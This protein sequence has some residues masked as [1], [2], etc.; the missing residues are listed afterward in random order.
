MKTFH[1]EGHVPQQVLYGP[2]A[3]IES[4]LT[5][6]NWQEC[7]ILRAKQYLY[8][9]VGRWGGTGDDSL[10]YRVDTS[11]NSDLSKDFASLE[12]AIDYANRLGKPDKELPFKPSSGTYVGVRFGQYREGLSI[13][14]KENK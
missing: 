3:P 13:P 9:G 7:A 4:K 11:P 2:S 6:D 14:L 1:Y 10:R 12:E 5:A 8:I